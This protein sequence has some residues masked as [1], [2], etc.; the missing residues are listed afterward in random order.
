MMRRRKRRYLWLLLPVML[1]ALPFALYSWWL[2][3]ADAI[4]DVELQGLA[5]AG[6][7]VS[8][9]PSLS[10][11]VDADMADIVDARAPPPVT[12][13]NRITALGKAFDGDVG[14]AVQSVE[15]G[16]VAQY[17]AVRPYPQQSVSKLWV[18][19]TLLDKVDA[20]EIS[21]DQSI[22]LTR[23]DLTIFHQPI[24]RRIGNGAYSTTLFEL[25]KLAMTRSDNTANDTLFRRVGGQPG[26]QGFFKRKDLS[27]IR[28]SRGEKFLQ[29]AIAGMQWDD[30]YSF[31]RAFWLARDKIPVEQRAKSLGVYL[32]NPLDGAHPAAIAD[33]LTRLQQGDLL[34]PASSALLIDL[35]AQSKTG[36]SRLR[37]GLQAGWTMPHK[38]G[39]GQDLERLST[40]YNDVG[41][42]ISPA[43][44]HYAV[45]VMI[46]AT[47]RPV[48]ERQALM[49]SVTSA[50]IACEV[51][52]RD[53]CSVK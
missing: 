1:I 7:Q 32:T 33:A 49:Q 40:A 5:E 39:T 16:W 36:P 46:G 22:T 29:M 20:G 44:R 14:I 42:L 21:L 41:I 8:F 45:V 10:T 43:G 6:H 4:E 12:L 47:N 48:P 18:A 34:S 23:A 3:D 11:V 26:V 9:S 35:M 50:V 25:L 2:D 28:I 53:G 52:R 17:D 51:E 15:Q 37:G 24:R 13:M 31:G 27:G 38:T 30:S 19:M